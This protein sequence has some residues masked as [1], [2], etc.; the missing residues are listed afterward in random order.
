MNECH[1]ERD[2]AELAR[3]KERVWSKSKKNER[4][5]QFATPSGLA[6]EPLYGGA[7]DGGFPGEFPFTRG[8]RPTMYRGRLWTMRQYAGF[9]SARDTNQRFKVLL[10]GGQ[11]GLSTAFDLPT[12]IG[13][14][15]DHPLAAPE[16]GLVGVPVNSLADMEL[17]F[18]SIPLGEV[19]TS[20]T[21]NATASILLCMYV[22]LCRRANVA[23]DKI[24]G[25][26]QNDILKEYAARGNYR[27]PATPSMRL[28]TDLM[29]FCA[30]HAPSWN[31]ISIS[32][33]HIREAGSSAVQEVAFTLSNGRAYVRAAIAAG[34][35]VDEFAPR[36][37]FF[38]NA[39]NHLFEEV[40]K[41]RAARRMWARIMREEFEA[42]DPESW[43]L[44]FHTQTA[45]SMLTSQQPDNN[46]VRVT[47][48]ALAAILGGTQSLHT[49]SRD[50]ALSLPSEGAARL[51]L[52]TQQV[53]ASESGVADVID[54]LG[55]SP[56]VEALTDELE[57]RALALMAEVERRG[58]AVRAIE[59]GFVQREIHKSA[60][61]W[62]RE[63]ESKTRPIVGVNEF[64][65]P[66][67]P[68][69]IFR[70][71]PAAREAVLADLQRVRE[72]RDATRVAAA[73]EHVAH[74]AASSAN[75]LDA[76]LPAVECYA[77]LGEICG[78]L[79]KRFG[80]YKA[81]DVL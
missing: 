25:T 11:T 63:V 2:A 45:G 1:D 57:A 12:Q 81:A 36:L 54:P 51:A 44:R 76:I 59:D 49:N 6:L 64:T 56:Y 62:Q 52:R 22:A 77:T 33:Y 28:V 32:G 37:S 17:L 80:V 53:L 74:A 31:T 7:P 8:V 61:A 65:M 24:R 66:E 20:M 79:E 68:P 40:A 30:R 15:S 38:F 16:V 10:A 69:Q 27:F 3:W 78:V 75:L 39:H 14:D 47:V 50:E 72:R 71:N 26:V 46:V 9:S 34:L 42:R 60:M 13:Y 29:S 67:P 18:D 43:M 55:G 41:F 23:P 70:P 21:I 48:Q 5:A 58:G 19:S 35:A 4:R 73:L